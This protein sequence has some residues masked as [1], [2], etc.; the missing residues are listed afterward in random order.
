MAES[1]TAEARAGPEAWAV[2]LARGALVIG[3]GVAAGVA[4]AAGPGLARGDVE[5]RLA[6][7]AAPVDPV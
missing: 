2:P 7:N 3:F 1:S 5:I 4:Q 6:V